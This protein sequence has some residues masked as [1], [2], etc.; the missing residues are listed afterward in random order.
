MIL[1]KDRSEPKISSMH[2][3]ELRSGE[4]DSRY[5]QIDEIQHRY[6]LCVGWCWAKRVI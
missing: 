1:L 6:V 5:Q 4:V 2:L 3:A